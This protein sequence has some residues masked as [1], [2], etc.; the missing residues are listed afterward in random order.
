MKL[1]G[2]SKMIE[3]DA[4]SIPTETARLVPADCPGDDCRS[5]GLMGERPP[6]YQVEDHW[7]GGEKRCLE[8]K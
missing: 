8:R 4:R 5:F 2:W 3:T 1:T 6:D 7:E